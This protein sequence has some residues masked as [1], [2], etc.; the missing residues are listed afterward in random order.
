M[1]V[2]QVAPRYPPQTGGVETHVR[3]IATRLV[4]RGHE[5]TVVTADARGE[6]KRTE[7][8]DGVAVR[9]CRAFA[10]G[11]AIHA[12]PG[13]ARAVRRA[14]GDVVHAHNYHA[15]ALPFAA[16]GARAPLVVTPHYHG[17]SPHPVRDRLLSVYRPVGRRVLRRAAA[18]LAVS[19]WERD[20]L[21][22]DFGVE[23]R[24]VPNG[25]DTE[26]F[27]G[28]EPT[29]RDRPYLLT[30]GRLEAYKGIQH[31]IRALAELPAFDLVV[32][33]SGPYRDDLAA[34]AVETG[35]D[36]RVEFR[37]YVDD[38]DLPGLYAGAAVHLALSLTEAFGLTVGEALAAGTP[39]VVRRAAALAEWTGTDGVV[40]VDEPTPDAVAHA[41]RG[42]AGRRVVASVPDWDGVTDAVEDVYH[43]VT[44]VASN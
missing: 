40:G 19:E 15:L 10:P 3:E 35:V 44:G 14:A 7:T 6:G 34:I 5:V 9:R 20:L 23:A 16:L 18:V 37:G 8:R 11:G 25:I 36:D 29:T 2:T 17:E 22:A 28:A 26:R 32:A 38:D 21:G 43:D 24:V 1:R 33:G 27:Q 41:V 13:V 31:A 39:V 42:V 30:V 12:A 4:D